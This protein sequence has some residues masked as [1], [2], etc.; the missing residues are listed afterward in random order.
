MQYR[1]DAENH[2]HLLK[3]NNE[4]KPL[5]GTSSV[6]DVLNKP[7][8]FWAL[9]ID[10]GTIGFLPKRKNVGGKYKTIDQDDR[11]E[12]ASKALAKIKEMSSEAYLETLETAY[13][14]HTKSLK[15][16]AKAGTDLHATLE[17]YIKTGEVTD[18]RIAPFVSWANHNVEKWL[19]S[20]KYTFSEKL[21][22]GGISDVGCILKNGEYAIIDFKSSKEAYI[23]Q[24]LQ[25]GGYA[26]Q[27][28]ENG[29]YDSEGTFIEKFDKEFTQ[30]IVVPFGASDITPQIR[31]D[32]KKL[33]DCFKACLMLY[34][35]I[36]L[37]Q[38]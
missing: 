1:F 13:M 10:L 8:I 6:M 35:L 37:E 18:D 2:I 21:W 20:E 7:L 25:I 34:K 12:Y 11:I 26:L 17:H 29:V 33:K 3:K 19:Y 38:K 16:S 27:I 5:V 30:Y 31:T 28:E 4:W 36:N 23:S 24:F 32:V 22:L 9:Q 14:A 15:S